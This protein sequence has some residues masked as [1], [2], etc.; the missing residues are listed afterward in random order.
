MLGHQ[1]VE[2]FEIGRKSLV[3]VSVAVLDKVCHWGWALR[4]Q[5][6]TPGSEAHS[7]PAARGSR[8]RMLRFHVASIVLSTMTIVN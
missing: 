5:K 8:Y 6:P 7:L 3:G 1:G 2:L 4:F